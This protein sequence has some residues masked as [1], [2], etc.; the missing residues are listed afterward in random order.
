MEGYAHQQPWS[1]IAVCV[2]FAPAFGGQ[3]WRGLERPLT[4]QP[5]H[6]QALLATPA[7]FGHLEVL[8]A[9]QICCQHSLHGDI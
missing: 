2:R 9:P 1:E 7:G 5:R 3:L 4:G 6:L 8:G